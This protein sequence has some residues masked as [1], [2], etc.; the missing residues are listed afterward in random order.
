MLPERSRHTNTDD[1]I[2]GDFPS[3]VVGAQVDDN[4][5]TSADVHLY[6][7]PRTCYDN[8]PVL[9]AD[10]EGFSGGEALPRSIQARKKAGSVFD[11]ARKLRKA[12]PKPP[13][14]GRQRNIAWATKD[15]TRRQEFFVTEL[16]PRVLYTFS[17]VV[18]FVLRTAKS[19]ETQSS[20]T[21][22]PSIVC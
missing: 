20:A 6:A 2:Q 22:T 15:E 21:T 4:L 5:T 14:R 18:V 19:V 9:Y 12:P 17:D 3:R 7:D 11:A 8:R 10:C 13:R 1:I 16:Y